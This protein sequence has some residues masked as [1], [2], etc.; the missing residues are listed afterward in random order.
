VVA[1]TPR[2]EWRTVGP[3]FGE[4]EHRLASVLDAPRTSDEIYVVCEQSPLNV[5]IRDNRLEVKSLEA[6]SPA[7]LERWAPVFKVPFPMT[8]MALVTVFDRFG[9]AAPPMS[10]HE[11]DAARFL[12][13]V[14]EATPR[15][16][17]VR[18]TKRRAGGRL[19]GC[20]V[21]IADLTFDGEPVRTLGLEHEDEAQLVAA[22]ASLGLTHGANVNYVRALKKFLS[23]RVGVQATRRQGGARS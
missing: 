10:R 3:D 7:G 12:R 20:I 18:V 14:V 4:V 6:V 13:E 16:T 19:N 15:L 8:P 2:W 23:A 5:K 1:I 22:L 11:Y 17:P 9:I 21:E